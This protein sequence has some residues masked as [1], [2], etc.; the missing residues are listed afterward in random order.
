MGKAPLRPSGT[1]R[2]VRPRARRLAPLA[3]VAGLLVVLTGC[4]S[5]QVDSF[6][7][8]GLPEGITNQTDRITTLWQGAWI[9]LLLVGA[10]VWGLIFWAMVRFRRRPTDVGVPA[11]VRYNLPVEVTFTAVPLI[12]V[13][14]YFAFTAR[15]ESE[16]LKVSAHPQNVV[17]VVGHQWAWDWNYLDQ[18]GA[19]DV[20][21][22]GRPGQQPDLWLPVDQS[23][24]FILT[25]RDVNHSFW[26]PAFQFKMDLI[27]GRTN[28][29]EVTPKKLGTFRGKCAELCGVDH[30]RMLFTLRV[31]SPED[32]LA[33]L[34]ELRAKGQTGSLSADLGPHSS[35]NPVPSASAAPSGQEGSQ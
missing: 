3:L 34:E 31:V 11:Q 25:T 33:H 35:G 7:R 22:V 16:I 17:N 21:D 26:V 20:F 30:S 6:K 14:F 5:D 24:K 15:D 13:L 10:L 12:L 2:P 1:A 29:F 27:A 8:L 4:S 9:S 28:T 19:P 32:Y 18:S 23:V